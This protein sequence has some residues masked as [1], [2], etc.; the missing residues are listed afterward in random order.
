MTQNNRHLNGKWVVYYHPNEF[1]YHWV[2]EILPGIRDW[3]QA[4]DHSADFIKILLDKGLEECKYCS[5]I[6]ETAQDHSYS[7][8]QFHLNGGALQNIKKAHL[9]P[10]PVPG[11][12][13]GKP[14]TKKILLQFPYLKNDKRWNTIDLTS[15]S[16]FLGSSLTNHHYEVDIEK[17]PLPI[18]NLKNTIYGNNKN[19]GIQL[20]KYQ[21]IGFT[22]F[23]DILPEFKEF[24]SQLKKESA[25]QGL[26]AGGGPM[27]TLN[28]LASAFHLPE[29][30]LLI[31]G[32]AEIILPK[33]L[34]AIQTGNPEDVF[35]FKGVLYQEPGIIILS[36]FNQINRVLDFGDFEFNLSFLKP[37]HLE[38]G[39]EINFSRGCKNSCIFCSKVQG[40]EIR[41]LPLQKIQLL[42][43][44]FS[45]LIEQSHLPPDATKSININDDDILQ[46]PSY[47]S[48][49][50]EHIRNSGFR[51]WGIQCSISSLANFEGKINKENLQLADS[52]ELF[53]GEHPLL[54]IGTDAFLK[55][56]GKR[57]GKILPPTETMECLL[58][59]LEKR[60]ILNYHY[61]I[62]SDYHSNW[63][64]VVEEFILIH[65]LKQN[66][67]QFS[68]IA[69]SPFLVPFPSTP[70]YSLLKGSPQL[71]NQIKYKSVL[72]AS[73]DIYR[74]PLVDRINTR[75]PFLNELL[76]NAAP[77]RQP[78]FFDLIKKN[79]FVNAFITLYHFLKKERLSLE[80]SPNHLSHTID[81]KAT[82]QKL[83][84]YISNIY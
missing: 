69:H 20:E 42:L 58:Q 5:Y 39:L 8:I 15:S 80:S 12:A 38:H 74:F 32:E 16:I 65:R 68:I 71:E 50:F 79:D 22:L 6:Q 11:K 31:R 25:F 30:N 82:E 62:S 23:E 36:D 3:L 83:E 76:S 41:K 75:F 43:D 21:L 72:G 61:W 54:W 26:L 18:I 67:S 4:H 10:Y 81:L 57:L 35:Q 84:D 34:E 59:E 7:F 47:A 51:L 1:E 53:M 28:P 33:I 66:Y 9:M 48:Q 29:L 14:S 52:K 78:G 64:E 49:V 60:E 45:Q 2:L 24:L 13:H 46:D 70:V 56:R 73:K 44:Q 37:K 27:I 17:I 19:R 55:S 77:D 40:K 63:Q